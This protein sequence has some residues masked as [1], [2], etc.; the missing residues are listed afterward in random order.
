MPGDISTDS[1]V[2]ERSFLSFKTRVRH[3][4]DITSAANCRTPN[5]KRHGRQRETASTG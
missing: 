4:K 5:P 3:I 1:F 2:F